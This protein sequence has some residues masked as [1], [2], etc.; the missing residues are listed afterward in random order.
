MISPAQQALITKHQA[1]TPSTYH[2]IICH[3]VLTGQ[4]AGASML[5][6][7]LEQQAQCEKETVRI[8]EVELYAQQQELDHLRCKFKELHRECDNL[9]MQSSGFQ[10][11]IEQLLEENSKLKASI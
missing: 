10:E 9:R 7:T 5:A 8:K 1:T 11:R 6:A 2:H 3:L 4:Y